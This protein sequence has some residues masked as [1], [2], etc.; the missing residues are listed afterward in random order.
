MKKAKTIVKINIT[1]SMAS[2]VFVMMFVVD[3]A[4]I[5]FNSNMPLVVMWVGALLLLLCLHPQIKLNLG[6]LNRIQVVWILFQCYTVL[7]TILNFLLK[8][9]RRYGITELLLICLISY[10]FPCFTSWFL[11]GKKQSFF[12]GKLFKNCVFFCSILGLFEYVTRIKPYSWI[13]TS[14]LALNNQLVFSSAISRTYRLTLFFYHP[15][16]YSMILAVAIICCLFIPYKN[17]IF[18]LVALL[19]M[20]INLALTQSRT[21][22]FACIIGIVFYLLCNNTKKR[23]T[24]KQLK[25]IL[26]Y[27]ALIIIL[28]V[29]FIGFNNTIWNSI[30]EVINERISELLQ[31]NAYGARLANFNIIQTLRKTNEEYIF[32]FG[33]GERFAITYLQAHTFIDS[34]NNAIDN[35]FLTILLNF[36]VIGLELYLAVFILALKYFWEMRYNKELAFPFVILIMLIFSSFLF[37]PIGPNFIGVLFNIIIALTYV[38]KK[39]TGIVTY[40]QVSNS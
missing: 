7:A 20:G 17:K 3:F 28:V 18:N 29:I 12:L 19:L 34:W 8:T 1:K 22:W 21:G 37:E 9:R 11:I 40:K 26:K 4:Q 6:S 38:E 36:G 16:Y 31:G 24:L 35:Q 25:G 2:I 39:S 30:F 15:T 27:G 23:I 32:V 14:E 10:I 13:I 5:H 33:G